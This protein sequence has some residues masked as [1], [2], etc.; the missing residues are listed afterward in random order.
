MQIDFAKRRNCGNGAVVPP[1]GSARTEQNHVAFVRRSFQRRP[2]P[3]GVVRYDGV[4]VRL[5][6]PAAK[7]AG[8]DGGV[9][10]HH[11][12]VARIRAGRDDFVPRRDN[13]DLRPAD[14]FQRKYTAREHCTDHSRLNLAKRRQNHI[15]RGDILADLAQVLP[16]RRRRV[17][18]DLSVP[19]DA[20]FHHHHRVAAF[21]QR[22]AGV[23]ADVVACFQQNRRG[24]ACAERALCRK[25]NAVHRAGGVVRR[26]KVCVNRAGRHAVERVGRGD[27]LRPVGHAVR[28]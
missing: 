1:G 27:H 11:F 24:F 25:R 4:C 5:R 16:G 28:L 22:V 26:A 8:K 14:R 13:A 20:V 9:E 10:L 18:C 15:P 7:H 21:R 17:Q 12:A 19:L 2:N 6:A 3:F 23:H